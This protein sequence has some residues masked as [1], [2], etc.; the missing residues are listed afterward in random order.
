MLNEENQDVAEAA[1]TTDLAQFELPELTT[2]T[3]LPDGVTAPEVRDDSLFDDDLWY[4]RIVLPVARNWLWCKQSHMHALDLYRARR[5]DEKAA[6]VK[7]AFKSNKDAFKDVRKTLNPRRKHENKWL[8]FTL[9][10]SEMAKIG[11]KYGS[12]FEKTILI[13]RS[14]K[15]AGADFCPGF[16]LD[17]TTIANGYKVHQAYLQGMVSHAEANNGATGAEKHLLVESREFVWTAWNL[18]RKHIACH[19]EKNPEDEAA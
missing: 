7:A 4:N 14:M 12:S 8:R 15:D 9:H 11:E 2:V 19:L 16:E 5:E 17:F 13:L 3:S 1:F 6:A 10:Q 18:S